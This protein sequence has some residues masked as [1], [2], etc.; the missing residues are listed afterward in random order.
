MVIKVSV[1]YPRGPEKHFDMDYYCS[2]HMPVVQ[3]LCGAA[4]KSVSV[5][6]GIAGGTPGSVPSFVAMGHLVFESVESFQASFG[7]NMDE[8]V[9]DVSNYTDIQPEI[10]VSEIKL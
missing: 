4:L 6:Q 8:I 1:F 10:Q 2:R 5:E 9:A 7:P 3:K